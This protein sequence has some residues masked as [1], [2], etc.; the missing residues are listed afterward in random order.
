[1]LFSRFGFAVAALALLATAPSARA[2]NRRSFPTSVVDLSSGGATVRVLGA[3]DA[4]A[5]Q[6][7]LTVTV[8]LAMPHFADFQAR[9]AAGDTL[10]NG[11]LTQAEMEAQYLPSAA[12]YAVVRD[13]LLAQGFTLLVE[14][15]NH[16]TVAVQGTAAQA[17]QAFSVAFSQVET[18]DG[19]FVSATT[20]PSVPAFL[21]ASIQSVDGLQ[22]H[23]RAH[24]QSSR[25]SPASYKNGSS[26]YV[27]PADIRAAYGATA[28]M[29]GAG[30]TIAIVMDSI[31]S[32]IDLQQLWTATGVAQS[33]SNYSEI[34][35]GSGPTASN[36][37]SGLSE[38]S[39]D[40]QYASSVAPGAAVRFY[41]VPDLTYSNLA[42]ACLK[43]LADSKT[44]TSL[45]VV[46]LSFGGSESGI[47]LGSISASTQAIAQLAAA[48]ITVVASSGDEG[49]N[50]SSTGTG[51][52]PSN[53]LSVVYP[54]SD[55]NVTGVG[56]TNLSFTTSTFANAGE[57][58]WTTI[59]AS[60]P[61]SGATYQASGGGVSRFFSRPSWQT[62]GGAVL[63][64]ATARCVP[65]VAAM[66]I[67]TYTGQSIPVVIIVGGSP[68][69]VGGTS[70]AAPVWAGV[71]AL[72]NQ[73]RASGGKGTV[74]L[75][76]SQAYPL[77]AAGIVTD[78]VGGSNGAYQAVS[79][80]D[81]T[82][83]LGSPQVATLTSLLAGAAPAITSS[84][85]ASSVVSGQTATFTV[86]ASGSP[87][88]SYAW[89]RLAAGGTSWSTLSDTAGSFQGSA[90]ST[91]SVQG[92]TTSESGD[93]YRCVATNA[94]GTATSSAATLTVTAPP[95]A[96]S[97]GGGG[98][99][100]PLALALLA[101]LVA[102]RQA[103]PRLQSR[104][105]SRA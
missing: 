37:S 63:S 45:S 28:S 98:A 9:L 36:Q 67:G 77:H 53:P 71:I 70:L 97:G 68:T 81:L 25:I 26:I 35:I 56:G 21:P 69:G 16:T 89:Q 88:P 30:Q 74:G 103:P 85:S 60:G 79:G 6:T 59:P 73:A 84:P 19:A 64:A 105:A 42:T 24:R 54:A 39:L 43:I 82:T 93:Q 34:N 15:P 78:I 3:A 49:S 96:S 22:P 95:P 29:T 101:L 33:L 91:L 13:W 90:T 92:T 47:T 11:R 76:G 58:L 48:G 102:V 7:P 10:A 14:D 5:L 94:L 99:I 57:A 51:Y 62:D 40:V 83:G 55:P 2:A 80:Y 46:S 72:V 31:P 4:R 86:S 23:V 52:S 100:S 8:S 44:V 18:A 75:F 66:S 104:A 20:E 50:P 27:S 41:A 12:D 65:D 61:A 1:M 38:A 17:A 87:A 32:T